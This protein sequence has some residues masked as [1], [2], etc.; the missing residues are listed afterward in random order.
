MTMNDTLPSKNT[1]KGMRRSREIRRQFLMLENF[2][3]IIIIAARSSHS[4]SSVI[5]RTIRLTATRMAVKRHILRPGVICH[6]RIVRRQAHNNLC[7]TQ[8]PFSF[9][10]FSFFVCA[11]TANKLACKSVACLLVC[12]LI[13]P[14]VFPAHWASRYCVFMCMC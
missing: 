2:S 12:V 6:Q 9:S 8:Y 13:R 3:H 4:S 14:D 10:I 7:K 1:R 5:T 11:S